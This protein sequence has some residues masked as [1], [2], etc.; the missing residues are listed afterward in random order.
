MPIRDRLPRGLLPAILVLSVLL[1]ACGGKREFDWA[2]ERPT[3]VPLTRPSIKG[4]TIQP[5]HPETGIDVTHR[6]LEDLRH[7]DVKMVRIEFIAEYG[8]G[9]PINYEA[10]DYVFREL[11]R[12]GIAVLG[13]IAYQSTEWEEEEEWGTDAFREHFVERTREIVSHYHDFEY[14]VRH[15]EIWNE[16]D[17]DA[18]NFFV[19]IEPEPYAALLR[20]SYEAIKAI[21]PDATVLMGGISPKYFEYEDR[22]NYLEQMYQTTVMQD[23]FALHGRYPF[24][25][26]AC[27]PYPEVFNDP[28]PADP[29]TP[30]LAR[31]LN[32]R[33]KAVMNRHGDAEKK[34]WLTEMG[35]N[36]AHNNEAV[37]ATGLAKSFAVV[38]RLVDPENPQLGPYVEHYTWFKYDSWHRNEEWGLVDRTRGRR[39]PAWHAFAALTP[40]HGQPP[41]DV[42]P[43][44]GA[45]VWGQSSDVGLS[46]RMR[47]DDLLAGLVP[48]VLSGSLQQGSLSSLTD[49]RWHPDPEAVRP[50]D[51]RNAEP[52]HLRYTLPS[53]IVFHGL[54]SFA[55]Q[56]GEGGRR[57]FQNIRIAVNGGPWLDGHL[58]TG[59]YGQ[60]VPDPEGSGSSVIVF[61]PPTPIRNVRTIDI[62]YYPVTSLYGEFRDPWSPLAH[63]RRDTDGADPGT[64]ATQIQEID[65]T[66]SRD[67]EAAS[68]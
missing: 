66:G 57:A 51:G 10:Y 15:W 18:P 49:G 9:R 7:L 20:D 14:P 21:D 16:Q 31:V 26:V 53:P 63:P 56:Y 25:A 55:G 38:D 48:D 67:G 46:V 4:T 2:S 35:W 60:T 33:I 11:G 43:G 24:D 1:A 28:D 27:H 13:L 62:V 54:R 36:S 50:A 12:R 29:D 58:T 30:S 5:Y 42:Q 59:N 68:R 17:L 45:P 37:Q 32:E 44:D 8:P 22:D 47:R 6:V 41:A 61:Q 52:L 34:V 64:I 23:Y 65:V 19:R 3:V 40:T 39:K